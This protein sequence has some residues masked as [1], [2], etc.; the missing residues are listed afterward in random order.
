MS[1]TRGNKHNFVRM[2]VQLAEHGEVNIV[3]KDYL[4][5]CINTFGEQFN[6]GAR[7]PVRAV[8]FESTQEVD[9]LSEE[10]S[11][12]FHHVVAK[13]TICGKGGK[14]RHRSGNIIPMFKG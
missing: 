6:G 2:D 10:K 13:I 7:T 4:E 12:I 8:C 9:K 3:F 11:E 14:T 1:V 5:K